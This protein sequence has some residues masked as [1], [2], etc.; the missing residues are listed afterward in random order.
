MGRVNVMFNGKWG[1]ICG[2]RWTMKNS[3][4]VC[5]QL[6]LGYAAGNWST[7][8]YGSSGK[9][10][11]SGVTCLGHED[12]LDDCLR[13]HNVTCANTKRLGA[14]KCKDGKYVIIIYFESL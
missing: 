13:H 7:S 10:H 3:I 8:N 9:I 2:E 6:G 14:V 12:S 4:V 1:D 11:F 5:R